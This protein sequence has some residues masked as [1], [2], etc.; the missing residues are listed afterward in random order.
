MG[1]ARR[2]RPRPGAQRTCCRTST[3]VDNLSSG[4]RWAVMDV[5]PADQHPAGAA[6]RAHPGFTTGR[7]C[8][9]WAVTRASSHVEQRL[10]GVG[11]PISG[12]AEDVARR[13]WSG[14][15]R[16]APASSLRGQGR[17]CASC[18]AGRHPSQAPLGHDHVGLMGSASGPG[19]VRRGDLSFT[20]PLFNFTLLQ[21]GPLDIQQLASSRACRSRFIG[22]V[23]AFPRHGPVYTASSPCAC[24]PG[25]P[26]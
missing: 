22:L 14:A 16:I 26:G 7:S 10:A 1:P 3:A 12:A 4:A 11:L 19:A 13:S 9:A 8:C 21:D 18:S 25:W 5:F 6:E 24:C 15:W 17:P 20:C 23:R 2:P